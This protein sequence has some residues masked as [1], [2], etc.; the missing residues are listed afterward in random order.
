MAARYEST[1]ALVK[2]GVVRLVFTDNK[3]GIIIV[4][5]DSIVM[6]NTRSYSK[7]LANSLFCDQA[8]N[9]N[10]APIELDI[11]M[12][13]LSDPSLG[14]FRI[15]LSGRSNVMSLDELQWIAF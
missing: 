5:R 7:W 11:F 9:S 2:Q 4:S 10:A 15:F 3:I 6:M 13:V 14:Y 12:P 8:M 1:L